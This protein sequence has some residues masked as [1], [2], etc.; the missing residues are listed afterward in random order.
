MTIGPSLWKILGAEIG[1]A[2]WLAP[3]PVK[4][5]TTTPTAP[6]AYYTRFI[7]MTTPEWLRPVAEP[8]GIGPARPPRRPRKPRRALP[9]L[10][11]PPD[12]RK[13]RLEEA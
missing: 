1:V 4:A 6:D 3:F 11:A 12:E 8:A 13:L 5:V 2:G 10:D 9:P 7:P